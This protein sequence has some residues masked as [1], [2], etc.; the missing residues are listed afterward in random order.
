MERLGFAKPHYTPTDIVVD[1]MH[2]ILTRTWDLELP[3]PE[4]FPKLEELIKALKDCI[5]KS[6]SRGAVIVHLHGF[7]IYEDNIDNIKGLYLLQSTLGKLTQQEGSKYPLKLLISN[8]A[9]S[10]IAAR[11]KKE[12]DGIPV[13]EVPNI[14][15]WER[16]H[17]E[18]VPVAPPVPPKTPLD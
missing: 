7:S 6:L 10:K 3:L 17:L 4:G 2:H 14:E 13:V 8:S 18:D 1:M 15:Q 11:L 9:P 16:D 12:T 5:W